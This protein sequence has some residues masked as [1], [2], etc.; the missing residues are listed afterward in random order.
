MASAS[1]SRA[2]LMNEDAVEDVNVTT[3]G[4]ALEEALEERALNKQMNLALVMVSVI[5]EH[6]HVALRNGIDG[7]GNFCK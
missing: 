2:D 4:N 5:T 6:G 1:S 3:V 7:R